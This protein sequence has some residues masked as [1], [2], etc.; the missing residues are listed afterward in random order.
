MPKFFIKEEQIENNKIIIK[1]QDVNHIKKVLRAKIGDELQICNSKNGE[2][3]LCDIENINN[4]DILCTIKQK[5][6]RHV[7][8]NINVTI[9]QGL[10][11]ADKMEYIIQKSVELGVYDITPVEMKRCVVKIDEKD[12]NKKIERWQKISEV[13]SKQCG[14]DIIPK[15]NN[16]VNVKNICD[17]IKNYDIVL[18]AYENEIESTL[19][20]QLK[21]LKQHINYDN[22]NKIKIGVVIGPEGGLEEQDVELLKENEAKIITLGKRILRTET[23][24]LN[25]LSIIMYELEN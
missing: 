20:E 5:L 15:I 21:Y 16:I 8:S 25:V 10:P 13:A 18:V 1:G 4:E 3:F 12:K 7:E 14:R 17:F 22:Q 23:V 9:F 6:E 19:K 2:N 24:A 11:K